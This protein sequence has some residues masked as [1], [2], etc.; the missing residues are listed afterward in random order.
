MSLL[1]KILVV[2]NLLGALAFGLVASLDYG[3]HRVWTRANFQYD[4][5]IRGLPLNDE[6][7]DA[8][9]RPIYQDIPESMAKELFNGQRGPVVLTQ[10]KEVARVKADLDRALQGAGSGDREQI[11]AY[12]RVL[13]PLARTNGQRERLNSLRSYL[14]DANVE[15]QLKTDLLGAATKADPQK[16]PKEFPNR[17]ADELHRLPGDSRKP[18]AE[19]L[20]TAL[21]DP[22]AKPLESAYNE[23]L[24]AIRTDLVAQ[25]DAAFKEAQTG[26]RVVSAG[27]K[28][29][30]PD[31]QKTAIVHLLFALGEPIA[32][33]VES[34]ALQAGQRWDVTTGPYR[35]VMTVC[36]FEAMVR[37]VAS[38]GRVFRSIADELQTEFDAERQEFAASD[39]ALVDQLRKQAADVATLS[40][41]LQDKQAQS[42]RQEQLVNARKVDVDKFTAE[43]EAL[44]QETIV[45][46]KELKTLSSSLYQVRLALRDAA[47]G[48]QQRERKLR[49]LEQGR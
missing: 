33:V 31:E 39:L 23:A 3:A 38:E 25:Y 9:G 4:V 37:E 8:D 22:P 16:S 45:R 12:A 49:E 11:V 17:L 27:S 24:T 34:E 19:A 29:L 1:G 44:R 40:Q 42:A 18:F 28:K 10:V 48:N 35:R 36:G 32:E 46:L 15:A 6:E 21:G 43:L 30:T 14:L 47:A 2:V 41:Q 13:L 26:D 20:L 5:F 7:K